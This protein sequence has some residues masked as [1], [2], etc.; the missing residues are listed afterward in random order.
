MNPKDAEARQIG[1]EDTICL[2]SPEGVLELPVK[3]CDDIIPGCVSLNEGTLA[4]FTEQE[5]QY[6]RQR[7]LC[8][9]Y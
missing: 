7:R 2:K 4:A 1:P 5:R 9:Y 8:K 6:D 3:I